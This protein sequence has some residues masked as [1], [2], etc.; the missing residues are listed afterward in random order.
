MLKAESERLGRLYQNV[1]KNHLALVHSLVTWGESRGL[2]KPIIRKPFQYKE[3]RRERTVLSWFEPHRFCEVDLATLFFEKINVRIYMSQ[4]LGR[5]IGDNLVLAKTI[6]NVGSRMNELFAAL[7][8]FFPNAKDP[9]GLCKIMATI[10]YTD[11]EIRVAQTARHVEYALSRS[12]YRE[13]FNKALVDTL[14]E[15]GFTQVSFS[16]QGRLHIDWENPT[17]STEQKLFDLYTE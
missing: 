2:P 14:H 9:K 12:V 4:P 11:C 1:P 15:E 16:K 13:Q 3:E 6:M 10:I 17:S 5:G 7:D 8:M